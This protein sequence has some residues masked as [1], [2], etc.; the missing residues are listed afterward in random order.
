[1]TLAICVYAWIAVV[2]AKAMHDRDELAIVAALFWAPL[3]LLAFVTLAVD[4]AIARARV[5]TA[6]RRRR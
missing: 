2:I 4:A 6:R 5:F 1:M 3:L